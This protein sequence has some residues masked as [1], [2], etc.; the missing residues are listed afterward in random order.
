MQKFGE[1]FQKFRK[2]RGLKLKDLAIAGLSIS[3]L[4]R[5][6]HRKTELTVTKFMQTLDELNVLLAEFMYVAHEFQQTS[7][8][9]LFAKLEAGLIFKNKKYFA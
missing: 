8:A 2:A 6:E 9:K 5:L 7:S 4:S 1:V 3:Q